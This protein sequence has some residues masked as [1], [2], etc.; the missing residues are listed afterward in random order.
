[1]INV[2]ISDYGHNAMND[3]RQIGSGPE[4]STKFGI[5]DKIRP[6]FLPLFEHIVDDFCL[7]LDVEFG[8]QLGRMGDKLAKDQYI[9]QL[10]YVRSTRREIKQNYLARIESFFDEQCIGNNRH[11]GGD[12]SKA[13]LVGEDARKENHA[14]T[15]MIRQCERLFFED[16]VALNKKF[17]FRYGKQTIADSENPVFP[18]KLIRAW[19]EAVRPLKLD[20]DAKIA[21]YK[22]FE[23][24]VVK[25]LGFV[26]GELLTRC[27]DV[28][29]SAG[30]QRN[31][32]N[33]Q[34][35]CPTL[36]SK[37]QHEPVQANLEQPSAEFRL[38][39]KKLAAWRLACF[40]SA[41]DVISTFGHLF[42]E[43]VEI[44]TALQALQLNPSVKQ[45]SLKHRLV[46]TLEEQSFSIDARILAR[47]DE[48]TMDLVALIFDKIARDERLQDAS[49][50][51]VLQ[52]E[53][54]FALAA[55]GQYSIFTDKYNPIRQ[56]LDGVFA[57]GLYLNPD[58]HDDQQIQGRVASAV[59]K[60][61]QN[62]R[63]QFS[64]WAA[65]NAEFL[66]Y[67]TK[68]KQ[69]S[70]RIEAQAKQL[71]VNKRAQ[72][73]ARKVAV[74]AVENSLAGKKLPTTIIEFLRTAW[75]DVLFA[76]YKVKDPQP[77]QW[78]KALQ[79][80]DELIVSVMPPEDE[81]QRKRI[82]K[83]LPGLIA[84]LRSGLKRI[85]YDK[86]A[87][88]RFFKELA[89][90]HVILM[91]KKEAGYID[92]CS[93]EPDQRSKIADACTV[94]ADKLALEG[95]VAFSSDAG[96]QW[97]KLAWKDAETG[98]MLFVGRNGAKIAEM[99]TGEFADKLR[100]QQ[101]VI[102]ETDKK[103]IT[104]RVITELMSL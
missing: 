3:R 36:K 51:A 76:A 37:E 15:L 89:V 25:Q 66:D 1:M 87:Q 86:P 40:P 92:N 46:K 33:A 52:L 24:H 102:V 20:V 90:R 101:A 73:M 50:K 54:P 42:Y 5:L 74:S 44:K 99:Q 96:R 68:Q 53:I 26:Y 35:L 29:T 79:A 81:Q 16:L 17:A 4:E 60:I 85:A 63:L 34:P 82:L 78:Q 72:A 71:T 75:L 6:V 27:E 93:V 30:V 70:Q 88:S 11:E 8:L 57:A 61:V 49:K 83:L 84:E 56:L 45:Q 48:D 9:K 38:L 55:I 23:A 13:S 12:F 67:M 95:W 62:N 43:Q 18:E 2:S 22:A 97:G 19:A 10:E 14:L 94:Q 91:D 47:E 80:M 100:A 77:E 103:T 65:E 41:Y 58:E 39:Q 59:K 64:D 28:K 21:L 104:E 32:A 69:R 31:V 7:R 98:I